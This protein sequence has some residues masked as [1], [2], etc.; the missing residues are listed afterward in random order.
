MSD[1]PKVILS[2]PAPLGGMSR[3]PGRQRSFDP[4]AVG[5]GTV[6]TAAAVGVLVF[7]PL[8]RGV[9]ALLAA[10]VGGVVTGHVSRTAGREF[11]DGAVAVVLGGVLVVLAANGV[12]AALGANPFPVAVPSPPLF[13]VAVAVAVG[14]ITLPV[15]MISALVAANVSLRG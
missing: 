13:G 14:L 3:V 12:V 6:S 4:R 10:V 2:L 8:P 15:G 7:L 1:V 11:V 9:A 5:V